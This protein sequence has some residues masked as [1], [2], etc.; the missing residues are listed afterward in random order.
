MIA[1]LPSPVSLLLT[2]AIIGAICHLILLL[3]DAWHHWHIAEA[4][5]QLVVLLVEVLHRLRKQNRTD[6]SGPPS[7]SG[8]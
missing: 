5:Y 6:P 7:K 3:I 1:P 8:E 4:A 2:I